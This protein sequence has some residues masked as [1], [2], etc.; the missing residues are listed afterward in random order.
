M[1]TIP[2][3]DPRS[4][5]A[6]F[7]RD[8]DDMNPH[9]AIGEIISVHLPQIMVKGASGNEEI[10][11][12]SATTSIRNM[13]AAATPRDLRVG[14]QI[15]TVGAPDEQGQLHAI[16]IRIMPTPPISTSTIGLPIINK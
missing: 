10:V 7:G 11:L 8:M 14:Q 2:T 4:I 12:L 3:R 6:P 1:R 9:G 5:F 13:R 16:F 15:V